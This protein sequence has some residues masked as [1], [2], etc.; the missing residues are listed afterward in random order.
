M[1]RSAR[2]VAEQK[3][4]DAARALTRA[5]FF[6]TRDRALAGEQLIAAVRELDAIRA[7]LDGPAAHNGTETSYAAKLAVEPRLGSARRAILDQLRSSMAH[8]PD[9]RGLTTDEL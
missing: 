7:P 8:M 2:R 3:V 9:K 4:I 5:G 1:A 6:Q